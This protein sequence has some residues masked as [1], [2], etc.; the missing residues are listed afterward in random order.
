MAVDGLPAG[1]E[2]PAR[3]IAVTKVSLEEKRQFD[4]AKRQEKEAQRNQLQ[5]QVGSAKWW[6]VQLSS[7]HE[8]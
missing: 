8:V 6:Y 3:N 1:T 2:P 5:Q 4:K 7:A